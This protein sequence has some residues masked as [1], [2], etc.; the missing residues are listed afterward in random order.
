LEN[1]L[2]CRSCEDHCGRRC[3]QVAFPDW[4]YR[5]STLSGHIVTELPEVSD[6]YKQAHRSMASASGT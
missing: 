3:L 2:V 5:S 1:C 6:L 4:Q